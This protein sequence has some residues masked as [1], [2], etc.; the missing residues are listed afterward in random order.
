MRRTRTSS[1][2][3]SARSTGVL[4]T[5]S[6]LGSRSYID[7]TGSVTMADKYTLRLGVNNLFDKDP[8]LNGSDELPDRPVQRQH[9]AADVRRARP[10]DLRPDNDRLLMT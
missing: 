10:A 1:C 6:E 3:S 8:P 4:A 5:D 7:L 2:R 9:L